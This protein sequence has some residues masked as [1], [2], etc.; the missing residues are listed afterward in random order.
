MTDEATES[1]LMRREER[2]KALR[3][4]LATSQTDTRQIPKTFGRDNAA[5]SVHEKIGLDAHSSF[6]IGADRF[7]QTHSTA[8][9]QPI[10]A[11]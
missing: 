1:R 11:N 9:S 8:V 2:M 5:R 10:G 6:I 4:R 3:E 7:G